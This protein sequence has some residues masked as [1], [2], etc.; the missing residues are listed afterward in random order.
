MQSTG[1]GA[2]HSSQ[3]L[4]NADR[5]P[6]MRFCAPTIAS[7][8]HAWMHSVQPMHAASSMQATSNGPGIPRDVSSGGASQPTSCA[9][10]AIV[11]SPPGGQQRERAG[12]PAADR[13]DEREASGQHE[14]RAQGAQRRRIGDGVVMR[15]AVVRVQGMVVSVRGTH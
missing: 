8:G 12:Q 1:Q 9:S 10:R 11:A 2:T 4:H 13:F 15:I 6:C 14:R 3:P 5:T 7:T